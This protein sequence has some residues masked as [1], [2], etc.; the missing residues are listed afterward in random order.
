MNKANMVDEPDHQIGGQ[1]EEANSEEGVRHY[2]HGGC[3]DR[4]EGWPCLGRFIL[5]SFKGLSS[6]FGSQQ[7]SQHSDGRL[8]AGL[9]S[10]WFMVFPAHVPAF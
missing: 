7:S 10:H 5:R 3:K 8:C 1:H 6:V 2:V 4:G 9:V